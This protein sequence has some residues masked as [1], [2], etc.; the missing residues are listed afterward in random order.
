MQGKPSPKKSQNEF[1]GNPLPTLTVLQISHSQIHSGFHG[2]SFFKKKLPLFRFQIRELHFHHQH[3]AH[4]QCHSDDQ[5][6]RALDKASE[7]IRYK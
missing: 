5:A 3:N 1:P 4:H 7:N 2:S 6:Q